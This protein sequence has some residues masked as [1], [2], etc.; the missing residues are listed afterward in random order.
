MFQSTAT[1][2]IIISIKKIR[3]TFSFNRFKEHFKFFLIFWYFVD[4][5][6]NVF[7]NNI[8]FISLHD[9]HSLT[10]WLSYPIVFQTLLLYSVTLLQFRKI[11]CFLTL[12]NSWILNIVLFMC[13]SSSVKQCV[14][15]CRQRQDN[16]SCR[17]FLTNVKQRQSQ[18]KRNVR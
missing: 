16:T 6:S 10:T 15:K 18:S 8:K 17:D 2:I 5:C 7:K 3:S 14:L 11:N 4:F 12:S 9:F 1:Y 13:H